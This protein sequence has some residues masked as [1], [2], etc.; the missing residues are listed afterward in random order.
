VRAPAQ[1]LAEEYAITYRAAPKRY[2]AQM[3]RPE[4]IEAVANAAGTIRELPW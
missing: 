3:S 4:I 2:Q 1:V